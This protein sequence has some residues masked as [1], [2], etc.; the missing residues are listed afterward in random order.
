MHLF[1]DMCYG[2]AI[3]YP[4]QTHVEVLALRTSELYQAFAD[5]VFEEELKL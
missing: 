2:L 5:R 4:S 1:S 3:H